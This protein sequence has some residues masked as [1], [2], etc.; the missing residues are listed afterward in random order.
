MDIFLTGATGYLGRPIAHRLRAAG[1]DVRALAATPASAAALRQAGFDVVE[2]RLEDAVLLARAAAGAEAVV[3]AALSP[4][5]GAGTVDARAVRALL[6][7]APT[8]A[9]V[10]Y[11]SG[12]WVLGPTGDAGVDEGAAPDAP[13]LLHW[14]PDVEQAVLGARGVVIRPG[15][16]YGYGGGIPA[17]LVEEGRV[18]GRVRYV[19]EGDQRW[20]TVH[21]DDLADL[22]VRA[23]E[24][25]GGTVL[26]GV[27]PAPVTMR[28]VAEAASTA[29]GVPGHVAAWPLDEARAALG[30]FAD[31]LALDQLVRGDRTRRLLGWQPHA[32]SLLEELTAG[33]Y[34]LHPADVLPA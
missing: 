16:A 9:P 6:A 26:H 32:P 24:A 8:G 7:G 14:R 34:A 10:L 12:V 19:A 17:M 13:A 25:P 27:N 28:A 23:L 29:A 3:H 1:H 31:A 11:T 21:V 20:P 4:G 22:Y 2:G 5:A 30:D 15:I 18:Q 33:S